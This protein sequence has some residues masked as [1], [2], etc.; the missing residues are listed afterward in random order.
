MNEES[1]FKDKYIEHISSLDKSIQPDQLLFQQILFCNRAKSI[2]DQT[3]FIESVDQAY[4]LLCANFDTEFKEND[5]KIRSF[6][7]KQGK[8]NM[9]MPFPRYQLNNIQ[10]E[11]KYQ[12]SVEIFCELI[13]L[14]KRL[15]I[16]F[17]DVIDLEIF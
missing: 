16:W 4:N 1:K 13:K 5:Q 17:K 2:G 7:G 10:T 9:N 6:F 14:M 12:M 3:A 8:V 11:L 15:G